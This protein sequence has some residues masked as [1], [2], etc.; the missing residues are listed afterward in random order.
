MG[1]GCADV[2]DLAQPADMT[3]RRPWTVY[4][5][6]LLVLA[7]SALMVVWGGWTL[8]RAGDFGAAAYRFSASHP[9]VDLGPGYFELA[10]VLG[11]VINLLFALAFLLSGF[12]DL[13][14]V[15]G[16]RVITW[17]V[18]S[19]AL[20]FVY[21]AYEDYGSPYMFRGSASSA[22]APMRTLTPWRFSGWYHGMTVGF[23]ILII[24][25]LVLAGLLLALPASGR[26]FRARNRNSL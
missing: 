24:V 12:L 2:E 20:P 5:A 23:G 14:G 6:G 1:I 11:A 13:R 4:V 7:V 22:A 26:Y 3:G 15:L 8:S 9:D 21:T 19:V 16:S 17:I 10:F 25:G 18:S